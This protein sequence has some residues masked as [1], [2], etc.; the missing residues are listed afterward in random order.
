VVSLLGSLLR[1]F[2]KVRD[3][4]EVVSSS[5]SV[6]F[7]GIVMGVL[8][9]IVGLIISVTVDFLFGRDS[10]RESILTIAIV[11]MVFT[12]TQS[13]FD[14]SKWFDIL[15]GLFTIFGTSFLFHY[16][17]MKYEGARNYLNY[18]VWDFTSKEGN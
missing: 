7:A 12:I 17:K 5:N 8:L 3:Y 1:F 11:C 6:L 2:L 18:T 16:L 13:Y 14:T 15:Q 10:N 4:M 9:T